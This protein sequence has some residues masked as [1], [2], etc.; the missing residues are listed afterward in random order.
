MRVLLIANTLPP[1]DVSGV[2][3][4]VLQLA[5]GLR[6]HGD[7]VAVLGRGPGPKVLFPLLVVPA[8]WRALRRFRPH[9]VQVHE[10]DGALAALLVAVTGALLTPRPLLVALL[11]VSYV[12][13]LR[14]VR[15]LRANGR[16]LGRP[17]AVEMRFRWLKAPLQILLGR[18]TAWV[19]D[20]VLAPS[21]ATA[22]EI[23]RDYRIED[24]GVIPNVTGG[25]AVEPEVGLEG[26]P[27]YLLFVGRLRI[28]KGV[29][30]L[31]EALSDLRSR[32]PAAILRIAGDGEHRRRLERRAAELGL[33]EVVVFLGTCDARR[34][35]GLLAG[36]AALVVPSIYEGMPLVVLEAMAAGV[37][38]VASA[39]SGIPEVVVDG[40]TGWLVPPEDP[41]SLAGALEAVLRRP[42]EA[43]RRGEAGRRRVDERFR[44]SVAAARW[45]QI[46]RIGGLSE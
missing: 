38:V 8:A 24:V 34:V 23:R 16:V 43:R 3:E 29:E 28:R 33:G 20:L 19:A 11:Q 44:P 41:R 46:V 45:R 18:L 30:V 5:A 12:E 35:R 10:S 37:P 13:E 39:V 36:A 22:A 15:S 26:E 4:Q 17:G 6:E 1:R 25:L 31:L 14:A 7:E 21:A 27:G 32:H 9:V 42:E 2:G 40:E